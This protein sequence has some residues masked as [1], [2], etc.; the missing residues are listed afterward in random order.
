M[1]ELRWARV[2]PRRRASAVG[3]LPAAVV[4]RVERAESEGGIPLLPLDA[5]VIRPARLSAAVKVAIVA[6]VGLILG[7][8]E[9][10]H[11]HEKTI[12]ASSEKSG[13]CRTLTAARAKNTTS[14]EALRPA[15]RRFFS[16][17][18]WFFAPGPVKRSFYRKS[19]G[20]RDAYPES[21]D[22]DPPDARPPTEA[23]GAGRPRAGGHPGARPETLWPA[24]L[25]LPPRR[26]VAPGPSPRLQ[27]EG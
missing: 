10:V 20:P 12:R 13:I 1:R 2:P 4:G 8:G 24:L 6:P 16:S 17:H 15:G 18:P 23:T 22:A 25:C 5:E 3:R 21:P 7:T 11:I 26:S 9:I 14:V 27:P 19:Q